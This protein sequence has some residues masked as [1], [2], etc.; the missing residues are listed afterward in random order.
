MSK[1]REAVKRQPLLIF[2]G[3][4]SNFR[5]EIRI[6]PQI[7]V[8]AS[9]QKFFADAVDGNPVWIAFGNKHCE[10]EGE[11]GMRNDSRACVIPTKL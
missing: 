8:A 5:F 3:K 4:I 11:V 9:Q 6:I 7:F 1:T 2:L 10:A